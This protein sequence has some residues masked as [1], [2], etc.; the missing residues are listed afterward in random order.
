MVTMPKKWPEDL[1]PE[2]LSV[3]GRLNFALLPRVL[4]KLISADTGDV[5]KIDIGGVFF[6]NKCKGS[7]YEYFHGIYPG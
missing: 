4:Y 6:I 7:L 1:I 5:S 3:A 2:A